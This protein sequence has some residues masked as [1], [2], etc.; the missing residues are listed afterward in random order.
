MQCRIY[1]HMTIY[2]E[3]FKYTIINNFDN[4]IY[5]RFNVTSNAIQLVIIGVYMINKH[6]VLEYTSY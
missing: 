6:M 4:N 1:Y 3:N 5:I 2:I